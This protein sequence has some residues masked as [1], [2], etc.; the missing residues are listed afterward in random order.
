MPEKTASIMQRSGNISVPGIMEEKKVCG[1]SMPAK[2]SAMYT[3][4]AQKKY[5]ALAT[6]RD[7]VH[8]SVPTVFCKIMERDIGDKDVGVTFIKSFSI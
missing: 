3:V 7:T 4:V 2:W 5:N 6:N 1:Q 8:L